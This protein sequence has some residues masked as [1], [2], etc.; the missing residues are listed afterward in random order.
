MNNPTLEHPPPIRLRSPSRPRQE[1]L[2]HEEWYILSDSEFVAAVDIEDDP[3]SI[4]FNP[5]G[6]IRR[7][8]RR[9]EFRGGTAVKD[10]LKDNPFLFQLLFEAYDKIRE[11][12]FGPRASMALEVVADPEAPRDQQL[13]VVIQTRF[14]P[15]IAH[16]LLSELDR[17]WWL[18]AL[19]AAQGKMELSLEYI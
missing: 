5:E 15:K 17:G 11:K 12:Y 13:F 14:R 9:Y 19:P 6:L 16:A 1:K 4:A 2:D 3:V 8:R 7:L 18:D 10:F